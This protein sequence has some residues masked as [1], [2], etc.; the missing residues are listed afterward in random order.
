LAGPAPLQSIA[1]LIRGVHQCLVAEIAFDPDP[2][3][4]GATTANSDKLAQRNLSIDHSDNPGNIDTHRVQHTFTIRPTAATLAPGR[5]PDELM[6]Q[7][8]STPR[9][10]SGTLYLPGLSGAEIIRMA[11]RLYSRHWLSLADPNS[12]RMVVNGGVTYV[13]IPPGATGDLPGLL[14]VGL[15]STVRRGQTFRVI[16]HQVIDGPAARPRP[17]VPRQPERAPGAATRRRQRAVVAAV[18]PQVGNARHILGAFQFSILV[19]T[20]DEILPGLE[21]TFANLQRVIGTVPAEN[22][23][24]PVMVRYLEQV[25][26]RVHA[27]GGGRPEPHPQP[28]PEPEPHREPREETR[29]FE[30]KIAGL[31]FDRFGDFEGFT[32]DTEGGLCDFLS[33]ERAVEELVT[34]AWRTRI[35]IQVVAEVREDRHRPLSIVLLRPPTDD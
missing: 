20:R 18:A 19:Q 21:R 34:R 11:D 35:A 12:I 25:A 22:R 29:R 14:T 13:P 6:I 31:R 10:T 32:L 16:V 17:P 33:R 15:P 24:H 28:R 9:G 27:L 5:R 7:W 30:G 1:D 2:I 3:P 23:W 4:T 8:G 26:S